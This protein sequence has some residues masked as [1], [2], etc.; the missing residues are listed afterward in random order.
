MIS[1][2]KTIHILLTNVHLDC[3]GE[4]SSNRNASRDES[5]DTGDESVEA[6][7]ES[8]EAGEKTQQSY[9]NYIHL[10]QFK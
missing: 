8:I 2:Y 3:R 9:Y 7:D 10:D 6:G 4:G 1:K 5:V